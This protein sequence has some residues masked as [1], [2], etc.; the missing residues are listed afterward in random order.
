[1]DHRGDG[2][3]Q[4]ANM[5]QIHGANLLDANGATTSGSPIVQNPR[6]ADVFATTGTNADQEW[7]VV[8]VGNCGDVPANCTTPQLVSNGAG[9][10]Y[11]IVNKV[12]G[13]VLATSGTGAVEQQAPAAAFNGDWVEPANNGQLWRIVAAH[14]TAS[15]ADLLDD[16]IDLVAKADGGSFTT[17]LHAALDALAW[18]QSG[19]ACDALTAYTNHVRAQSG[20]HLSGA[21]AD[22]LLANAQVIDGLLGCQ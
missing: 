6:S 13:N 17:Q 15:P 10:Y 22:R 11:I 14:I 4:I 18:G 9:D 21:L 3:F 5:N 16:Q 1:M 8:A 20:K 19:D 12:T 2:F 7:D